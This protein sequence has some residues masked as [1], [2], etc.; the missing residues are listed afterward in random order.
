MARKISIIVLVA[1]LAAIGGAAL[2]ARTALTGDAVRGALAAQLSGAIGQPVTIGRL[3][4]SAFPRVLI[5][6]DDVRIG[7]PPRIRL[8]E[9]RI[10]TDFRA[11]LSRRIEHG[12]VQLQRAR[13]ELPLPRFTP[14]APSPASWPV[15]IVSIDEIALRDVEIV[16]GGRAL[17][18]DADL[19]PQAGGLAL[20]RAS[21]AADGTRFTATGTI[22]DIAGP[23]AQIDLNASALDVDAMLAFASAFAGDLDVGESAA[24][25][26]VS[27]HAERATMWGVA[28]E[29]LSGRARIRARGIEIDPIGFGVFGGR[30]D[31]TVTVAPERGVPAFHARGAVR[32]V[33]VAA[34]ARFGGA[35]NVISG[36]LAAT[37][38]WTGPATGSADVMAALRGTARA[39]IT[40]GLVRNLGLLRA[41]VIATSMRAGAF[42]ALASASADEPFSRLGATLKIGNG[43]AT[44]DDLRFQ[45]KSLLFT[46]RG[47]VLLR[48]SALDLQG[49]VQLSDALSQQAGRDLLRYTQEG[50]R[51]TLPATVTGSLVRP[52]VSIDIGDLVQR[53]LRNAAAAE[54]EKQLKKSL[55]DLMKR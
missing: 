8:A 26:V 42:G 33:D 12:S 29:Q 5:H 15:S 35:P 28:F 51:V 30:Y 38:D 4:A 17:R 27:L 32:G 43:V 54:L 39:D 55:S 3:T 40:D 21:F 2:W 47:R 49:K 50:G 34:A 48:T 13:I 52:Q 19:A 18:G 45:S 16:S 37:I 20:R 10:A 31:G 24:N 41:A 1:L 6:L 9:L 44:T 23:S 22:A 53:A 14:A 11:L 46:A 36:R 25:L 7:D